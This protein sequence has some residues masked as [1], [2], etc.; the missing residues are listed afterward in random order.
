VQG[1]SFRPM[2]WWRYLTKSWVLT[3]ALGCL[4][5]TAVLLEHHKERVKGEAAKEQLML[6]LRIASSKLNEAHRVVQSINEV[7][8]R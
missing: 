8:E 4:M 5:M 7:P 1:R 3:G 6:G 2:P